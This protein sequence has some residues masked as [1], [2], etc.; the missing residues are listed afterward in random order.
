MSTI[1]S[2]KIALSGA[3]CYVAM[4]ALR[5]LAAK[6]DLSLKVKAVSY[7]I[8]LGSGLLT[9]HALCSSSKTNAKLDVAID[10]GASFATVSLVE[11]IAE[12]LIRGFS[13]KMS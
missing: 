7:A 6:P 13:R 12:S 9:T 8:I 2:S 1:S 11:K 10:I 5:L 3:S 4:Q